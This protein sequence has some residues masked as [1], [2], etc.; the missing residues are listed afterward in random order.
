MRAL[1]VTENGRPSEV[2]RVDDVEV[3]EPDAGTVRIAV[4]AA[5]LNFNDIQRCTGE[6]TTVPTPPPFTLGM[7][8]CG[9][10]DAAGEGAEHWVGERVV[11]ITQFAIGGLAE[12]AIAPAAS[13]FRAPPELDD[14]TAAG[15]I[16]P[17]HTTHLALFERAGLQADETLLIHSGASGLG[18]AAIQLGQTVGANVI[19]TA[20]G[21]EKAEHCR[22]L[23]ADLVIDHRSDDFAETVLQTTAEVGADV[24]Y[25]LAGGAFVEPSWRCIARGGRYVCVGFADD[26]ENGMTG[27]ALRPLCAGNFSIVGV[28]LAWLADP[29]AVRRFGINPYG[30]DV[31]DQTHDRLLDLIASG[32]ITPTIG[33]TVTLDEAGAALDDHLE[34][35]SVGRTVVTLGS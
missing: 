16:I 7:D 32:S 20:G 9:V 31:A 15:F 26:D 3:P 6:L 21:T 25:D 18:S 28:M 27:R 19:A 14:A 33:R 12:Y 4:K 2:L 10:V 1:R 24:I 29:L 5:S 8:V 35:R 22:A 30:R 23:G 17:F 13:V 11:A 34:R